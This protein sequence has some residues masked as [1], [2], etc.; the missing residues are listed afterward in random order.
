MHSLFFNAPSR[1]SGYIAQTKSSKFPKN[2]CS[3]RW[4]ESQQ[5]ADRAID[6]WPSVVYMVKHWKKL[7][8]SKRPQGN[9]FKVIESAIEDPLV[10]VKLKLKFFSYIAS[11][12]KPYL[13]KY[14]SNDPLVPI[15]ADHAL[16][17][18]KTLMSIVYKAGHVTDVFNLK[19][20]KK[21]N[22]NET[23]SKK[24]TIFF[25][26][27]GQYELDQLKKTDQ[28]DENAYIEINESAKKFVVG[29]IEKLKS[30]LL[31]GSSFL[32][33]TTCLNP[34]M[35]ATL[36]KDAILLRFQ[37]LV[38]QLS[39]QKIISCYVGDKSLL[40][41]KQLISKPDNAVVFSNFD[42]CTERLDSF[43]FN[44][45]NVQQ[46]ESLSQVIKCVLVLF[47]GQSQ[48]ER[49]F[50]LNKALMNDNMQEKTVVSRRLV[51]DFM[52]THNLKPF[53]VKI[54]KELKNSV[55]FTQEHYRAWLKQKKKMTWF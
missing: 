32:H 30:R 8:P 31:V 2:F 40:E 13:S 11:L 1:R 34:T 54:T 46:Y 37:H 19:H 15:M 3:H 43:F 17:V 50:S 16:D 14:Q 28:I 55:L 42:S 53:D 29:I 48:V 20:L 7:V 10:T 39:Q 5:V 25:G 52:Q 21:F 23:N 49:G 33:K 41:F 9:N 38:Q 35:L 44:N 12:L 45:L 26:C 36:G 4:I 18:I 27:A 51:K 6:I 22:F 24:R 47:H